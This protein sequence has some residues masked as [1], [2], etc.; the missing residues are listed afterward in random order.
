MRAERCQVLPVGRWPPVVGQ[1]MVPVWVRHQEEGGLGRIVRE[2]WAREQPR[3]DEVAERPVCGSGRAEEPMGK[4][5]VSCLR[6]EQSSTYEMCACVRA[7]TLGAE[8]GRSAL[9]LLAEAA[10]AA[11]A[12]KGLRL[13][14]RR[15]QAQRPAKCPR[16]PGTRISSGDVCANS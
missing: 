9:R 14:W 3:P 6:V 11:E 2:A 13:R 16:E 4:R 8:Q 7:Y 10:P 15:D 12:A 1:V 5:A